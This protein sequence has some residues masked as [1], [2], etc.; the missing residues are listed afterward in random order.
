[1]LLPLP[2]VSKPNEIK[3]AIN[4]CQ[5]ECVISET[6]KDNLSTTKSINEFFKK[7]EQKKKK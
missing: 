3:P 2:F 5:K 7:I 6:K 4:N 1:M